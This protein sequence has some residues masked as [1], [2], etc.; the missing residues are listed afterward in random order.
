[1]WCHSREIS[2]SDYRTFY[3]WLDQMDHFPICAFVSP[4]QKAGIDGMLARLQALSHNL[5][6][7]DVIGP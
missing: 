7:K 1:M 6:E 4:Q 2:Y 3:G 5:D